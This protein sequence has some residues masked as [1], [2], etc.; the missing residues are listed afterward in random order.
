[1]AAKGIGTTQAALR[2]AESIIPDELR[3][4]EGSRTLISTGISTAC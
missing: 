1:V 2:R 3:R 4:S